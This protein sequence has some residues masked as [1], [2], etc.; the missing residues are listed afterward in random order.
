MKNSTG[1][2]LD[3]AQK[4]AYGPSGYSATKI[5]I[6]K[7]SVEYGALD[8]DLGGF[9]C[10]YRVG[11]VTPKKFGFFVTIWKRIGSG[12]IMPYDLDD[13]VDFFIFS[14]STQEHFGQFIFPKAVL[15]EKGIVS[16]E[17]KGGKRA[18][19]VYPPWT[20]PDSRQAKQTQRWQEDYFLDLSNGSSI[21]SARLSLLLS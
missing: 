15:V 5:I 17:G 20:T 2:L 3:L 12:P 6:E 14:V 9:Q 19:R 4:L 21:V 7:E 16:K 10:K 18:I 11:K 1:D 13:P 8:F